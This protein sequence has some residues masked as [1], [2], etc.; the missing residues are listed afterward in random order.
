METELKFALSPDTRARVERRLGLDPEARAAKTHHDWTTYFDTPDLALKNAGFTLRIRR[1]SDSNGF[2]QTVKS[3]RSS[4]L[5]RDE[6]E[7]PVAGERPDLEHL[8]EVPG[9]PPP[10]RSRE[11]VLTSIFET[12]VER[13]VEVVAPADG[14]KVEVAFDH[15]AIVSGNNS[16]PLSELEIELK[17]GTAD[18]L[19]KLGLDFLRDAPLALMGESKAERGYRLHD[20]SLAP[21]TKAARVEVDAD[22]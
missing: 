10:L 7:W 4:A 12:D 8:V 11:L 3:R 5:Q 19:L 14:A 9:L 2:V 6:W 13:T 18:S 1:R 16:E 22:A 21:A 15:G 20:G 17:E